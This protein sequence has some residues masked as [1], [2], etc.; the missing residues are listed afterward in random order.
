MQHLK[1]LDENSM[2]H[3]VTKVLQ[4][5]SRKNTAEGVYAHIAYTDSASAF[6]FMEAGGGGE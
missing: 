6:I 1:Y 2:Q 4:L 5:V 3:L